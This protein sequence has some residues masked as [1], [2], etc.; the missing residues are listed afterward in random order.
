MQSL[1]NP[2]RGAGP[3]RQ[4]FQSDRRREIKIEKNIYML[5]YILCTGF[6]HDCNLF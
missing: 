1:A 3:S 6:H 2:V 4:H 5:F